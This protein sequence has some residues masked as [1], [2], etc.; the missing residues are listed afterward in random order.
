MIFDVWG[1]RSHT[2]G[3]NNANTSLVWEFKCQVDVTW[4]PSKLGRWVEVRVGL[5]QSKDPSR[6]GGN[7]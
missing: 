2:S 7:P 3:Q 1:L 6:I 5:N 4:E